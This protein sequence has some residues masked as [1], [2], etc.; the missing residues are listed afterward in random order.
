M[1][2]NTIRLVDYLE[3]LGHDSLAQQVK[4]HLVPLYKWTNSTIGKRKNMY[5]YF[6]GEHLNSVWSPSFTAPGL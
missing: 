6:G 4:C 3:K 2:L 1:K 5:F